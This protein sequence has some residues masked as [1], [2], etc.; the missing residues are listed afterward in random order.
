MGAA[1]DGERRAIF[2]GFS[3]RKLLEAVQKNGAMN[4]GIAKHCVILHK[5]FL[6]CIRSRVR[7]SGGSQV[8]FLCSNAGEFGYGAVPAERC[9]GST[10]YGD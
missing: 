9:R 1:F 8:R 7:S 6:R 4:E 5:C 2:A 3:D 10:G